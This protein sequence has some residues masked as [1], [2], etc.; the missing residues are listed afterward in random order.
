MIIAARAS[1]A[2]SILAVGLLLAIYVCCV[3][4]SAARP[5]LRFGFLSSA[6]VCALAGS[7]K[8]YSLFVS[9]RL[10]NQQS[11]VEAASQQR[12]YSMLTNT[13]LLGYISPA[14]E[15]LAE[16]LRDPS[17]GQKIDK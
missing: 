10:R 9:I 14:R 8:K 4:L 16:L 5:G 2:Q 7:I 15:S 17:G 3:D 1:V 13:A 6:E 11:Q 12:N